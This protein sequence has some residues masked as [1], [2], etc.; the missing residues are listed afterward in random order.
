MQ[1]KFTKLVACA[2]TVFAA[3]FLYADTY[4]LCI[5]IND[6]PTAKDENGKD[7]DN[8]LNGCVNDARSM[9]DLLVSKFGV[10]D[11]HIKV[12]LDGQATADGFVAGMKWLLDS[13]KAGDQVVFSYSGHG[14]RLEDKDAE[15]GYESVIVLADEQLVPGK[16]FQTI[17]RRLADS[18]VNSTYIFDSC[19]SGGMSR[20]AMDEMKIKVKSLGDLHKGQIVEQVKKKDFVVAKKRGADDAKGQYAFLFAG[21]DDQPTIDITLQDTP[22]HGLFTMLFLGAMEDNAKIAVKDLFGT[23]NSILEEINKTL[24]EKKPDSEGFD[25][26][27]GFDASSETR[28][29]EP[30]VIS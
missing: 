8:D 21:R 10:D 19:F 7:V 14:A 1:F 22:A 17:S 13:A 25:Q 16:L 11:S 9:H 12:L 6:Y 5:G 18:G 28:A 27:P 26:K 4:A 29:A 30:I 3:S 20:P 23:L 15:T 2:A 24:K